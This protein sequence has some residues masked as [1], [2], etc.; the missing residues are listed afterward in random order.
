MVSGPRPTLLLFALILCGSPTLSAQDPG[1]ESFP[2]REKA[3]QASEEEI[4]AR[5]AWTGLQEG[6]T[7][8]KDRSHAA[9]EAFLGRLSAAYAGFAKQHVGTAAAFEA[10]HELAL[11]E[12]H[13]LRKVDA[14]LA[15]MES[16]LTN[17]AKWKGP[18]PEGLR[19]DLPNY[20]FVLALAYADLE[21]FEPAEKLL[22]PLTSK[23]GPR[24]EQAS[25]LLKRVQARKQLQIGMT[26]PAFAG[27]RLD[28]TGQVRLRDL[29]G[30]VV[31]IQ[32]WATWSQACMQEMT[33]L[34]G[35]HAELANSDFQVLGVSLDDDRREGRVRAQSY[36]KSIGLDAPQ[37]YEGF[38]WEGSVVQKFAVRA[39]PSNF[40]LD[41][42]GVIRGR[43]LR[44]ADLKAAVNALL[45]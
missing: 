8:P 23:E 14:G 20:V 10:L 30:K 7:P 19:L 4:A 26:M 17:S 3:A 29:R 41:A 32:F 39:I 5:D 18:A 40:L 11:M 22:T 44:G 35:L 2:S 21:R 34:A 24:G 38:G 9:F 33:R 15:R 37:I 31:L 6:V 36:L 16:I 27:P 25:R 1:S 12:I 13:A 42:E 43:N 28:G 45:K